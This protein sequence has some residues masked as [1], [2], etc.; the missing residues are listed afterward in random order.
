[1]PDRR[2]IPNAPSRPRRSAPARQR[3]AYVVEFVL[4]LMVMLPVTFTAGEFGRVSL[5]DQ[6]LAR[7]THRAATAAGRNAADCEIEA[8]ETFA[9]DA[10][11]RWLFD[12]ND[13]GLLGFVT[14][15]VPD[16]DAGGEVRLDI[17][18]DDGDVSNGIDFAA[19]GCGEAGAWIR[20]EATVPI[21]APFGTGLIV[22]RHAAWAMNQTGEAP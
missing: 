3:G 20:A 16:P 4:V 17:A 10:I 12:A 21:R 1:M 22:R 19:V 5:S 11:A 8:R 2:E 7:A 18:A 6:I 15:A 14:G 9:A 13:D